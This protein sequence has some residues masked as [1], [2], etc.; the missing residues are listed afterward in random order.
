VPAWR[1]VLAVACALAVHLAGSAPALAGT[2]EPFS[3]G[4]LYRIDRQGIAPS[5]IFG[6]VHS[7]DARVTVLPRPVADAFGGARTLALEMHPGDG[8]SAAFFAAAQFDDGR[9]LT[10]FFDASTLAAIRAAL[11]A[12]APA[13]DVFVRLKPWAVLLRLGEQPVVG[14]TLDA[15]LQADARRRRL[16][17]IGLE[18][19]DEQ[20]SAFDAIPL[21]TQVAL[22]QFVLSHRAELAR[23][24]DAVIAAWLARDLAQLAALSRAPGR[25]TPAIAPHFAELTRHLVENRSVQMAHRLFLPLRAGRVFVAVGALHLHGPRGVLALLQEQGYRLSV[26]Y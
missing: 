19:P 12:G 22:V 4:L 6:T 23:E 5:Y 25:R 16:N 8:D 11:G 3:R 14:E 21:A 26:V 7:A 9:R 20:I 2:A 15:K 17:V 10:D 13:D 1:P 18:L 24:H